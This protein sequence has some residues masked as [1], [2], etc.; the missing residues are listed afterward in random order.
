MYLQG[1]DCSVWHMFAMY[2]EADT[3]N[4]IE[5]FCSHAMAERDQF[6]KW[7]GGDPYLNS[8]GVWLNTYD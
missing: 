1:H 6:S 3:P 2:D 5:S 8:P 7:N 4:V